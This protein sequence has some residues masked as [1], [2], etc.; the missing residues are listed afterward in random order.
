[1][2]IAGIQKNSL[3]DFPGL[4]ACVIFTAG[5]NMDC[6][7]CH[8]RRLIAGDPELIDTEYVL[9]FLKKRRG[10]LEGVVISGGEPTLQPDLADFMEKVKALGFRLKLDTNGGRPDILEKV[11]P[12]TDYAAMD[13]KA[14]DGLY[15]SVCG[16]NA[17]DVRRSLDILLKSGI[18]FEART[19]LYPGMT[20]DDLTALLAS[21]PRLPGWRLNIF[22]MPEV[23]RERDRERLSEKALT[24]A[25]IRRLI[26]R[27]KKYQ[28]I[29]DFGI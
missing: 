18:S 24:G 6:F 20:E 7:Y 8:N 25:D 29:M 27:L 21:Y 9:S 10:L 5:C 19:T 26:P 23:F 16:G 3:I 17:G 11:L 28:N 15:G 2:R 14:E 22:R 12:L 13:I 1:M 4:P